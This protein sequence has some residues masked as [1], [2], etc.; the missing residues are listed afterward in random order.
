MG[1]LGLRTASRRMSDR[2]TLDA[3]FELYIGGTTLSEHCYLITAEAYVGN[4]SSKLDGW[5]WTLKTSG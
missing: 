3:A 2:A 4:R 5:N 1:L